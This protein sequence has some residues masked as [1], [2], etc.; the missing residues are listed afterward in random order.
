MVLGLVTFDFVRDETKKDEFNKR[1]K[2]LSMKESH[3]EI[4]VVGKAQVIL[5]MSSCLFC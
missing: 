4:C 3:H 5:R 1:E 2:D